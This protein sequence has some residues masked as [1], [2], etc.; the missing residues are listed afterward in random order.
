MDSKA[1]KLC[2]TQGFALAVKGLI[3]DGS[4]FHLLYSAVGQTPGGFNRLDIPTSTG[5]FL[6]A[7]SS[8]NLVPN[9]FGCIRNFIVDGVEPVTNSMAGKPD[10]TSVKKNLVRNCSPADQLQ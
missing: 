9:F 3:I 6:G 7:P 5:Y 4:C 10:Y 1:R 8:L 2:I